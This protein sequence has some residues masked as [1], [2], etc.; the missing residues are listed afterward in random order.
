[1]N[2]GI[3]SV[4]SQYIGSIKG[5]SKS[6][7]KPTQ[8][9]GDIN[10]KLDWKNIG[11]N[12]WNRISDSILETIKNSNTFQFVKFTQKASFVG[13]TNPYL[14]GVLIPD[15]RIILIP[16]NSTTALIY[17]PYNDSTSVPT[18]T[19]G[20]TSAFSAGVLLPNGEILFIPRRAACTVYNPST[21]SI[22]TIGSAP[23]TADAYSTGTLLQDGRVFC[24]AYNV[25]TALI[26]D[27]IKNTT[28]VPSG[29]YSDPNIG[30]SAGYSLCS[31]LLHDGRVLII[32]NYSASGFNGIYDPIS[33]TLKRIMTF[34]SI[35]SSGLLLPNNLVLLI[36][37]TASNG[38]TQNFI[39]YDYQR[40]T[41]KLSKVVI[42][43]YNG[44]WG[45]GQGSTLLPDGRVFCQSSITGANVIYDYINDRAVLSTGNTTANDFHGCTILSDGRLIL[46][47]RNSTTCIGY[48]IKGSSLS[49]EYLIS[50][51]NNFRK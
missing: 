18:G 29:T 47:P 5:D 44:A 49:M 10:N 14:G 41:M 50:G 1:M 40:N 16:F 3:Y 19:Y 33:N 6:L 32:N 34:N 17:D 21:N 7:N 11:S 20:G 12:G 22:R 27:P 28:F 25:T 4:S 45:V 46:Y 36:P 8:S 48:G 26:I 38:T 43:A 23:S 31:V 9:I 42:P 35:L 30:Q 13:G 24:A 37:N 51:H 39:L 2:N 15:G